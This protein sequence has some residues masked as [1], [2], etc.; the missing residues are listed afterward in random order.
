MSITTCPGR[1]DPSGIGLAASTSRIPMLV[2]LITTS[3]SPARAASPISAAVAR[4]A[5]ASARAF[6][7]LRLAMVSRAPRSTIACA[8]RRAARAEEQHA[9]AR[10]R[11]RL[12]DRARGA[13]G[14]GVVAGEAAAVVDDG[15][16]R[17]DA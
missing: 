8:T 10:D 2:A 13:V 5:S 12:L 4:V 3:Y 6:S 7:T 17:A 9:R 1:I 14:V 16:H 11:P 15:V